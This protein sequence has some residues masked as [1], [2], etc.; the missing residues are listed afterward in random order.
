MLSKKIIH[1]EDCSSLLELDE[2]IK[3]NTNGV[4]TFRY[5]TKRPYNI[6]KNHS[7]TRL[8]YIDNIC[9][10]YGHLDCEDNKTWLGIMVSDTQ[11]GNK[12]GDQIMDDLLLNTDNEIYLSVDSDNKKAIHLYEKKQF[13]II[14]NKINHNIMKLKK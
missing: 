9:V 12:I 14:E 13:Q 5:Y 6:I 1:Y 2:F 10:G 8:Y 7:Y 11:I 3:K 4:K